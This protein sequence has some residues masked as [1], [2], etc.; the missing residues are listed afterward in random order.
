[1]YNL[2]ASVTEPNLILAPSAGAVDYANY[3]SAEE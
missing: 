1:M 3:I 2:F